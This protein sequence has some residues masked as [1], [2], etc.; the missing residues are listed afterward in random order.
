MKRHIG[1]P[2]S[3]SLEFNFRVSDLPERRLEK[4]EDFCEA[5]RNHLEVELKDRVTDWSNVDPVNIT[6]VMNY[7]G[8]EN[9]LSRSI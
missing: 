8:I 2:V 5:I 9:E 1:V 7:K 3:V 6:N 4:V